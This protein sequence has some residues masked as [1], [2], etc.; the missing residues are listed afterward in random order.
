YGFKT[1]ITDEDFPLVHVRPAASRVDVTLIGY[2]R[3]SET[4]L[5]VAELLFEENE[6]VAEVICPTQ[7]Y[8]FDIKPI[9]TLFDKS[10]SL[11]IVE[12]GQGFAGFGSEVVAQ[13]AEYNPGLLKKIKR[14]MPVET[15]IPACGH[16]EKQMLP[17]TDNI[18]RQIMEVLNE[19]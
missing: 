5:N 17:R 19:V 4:L 7:I 3:L 16:L 12:E 6:I 1:F 2:G 11:F 14:I 13:I 10:S 15:P 18:I 8:P 9:S